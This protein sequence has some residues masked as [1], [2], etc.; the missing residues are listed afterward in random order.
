MQDPSVADQVSTALKAAL[1]LKE[2][3]YHWTLLHPPA[4][5]TGDGAEHKAIHDGLIDCWEMLQNSQVGDR[6]GFEEWVKKAEV[7][8]VSSASMGGPGC[9]D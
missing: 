5:R 6:R 2:D 8:K 1:P 4:R 3:H 9:S 7:Y